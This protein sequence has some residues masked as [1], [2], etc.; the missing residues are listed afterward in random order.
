MNAIHST[1][2]EVFPYTKCFALPVEGA[3][4]LRNIIMMGSKQSIHY[5]LRHIADFSEFEAGQGYLIY[6]PS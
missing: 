6:D 2:S 5:Q 4:D 1:L 3:R